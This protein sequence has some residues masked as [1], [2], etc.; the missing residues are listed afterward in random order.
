MMNFL[1]KLP[2]MKLEQS[3]ILTPRI[4]SKV[5]SHIGFA[6]IFKLDT[7]FQELSGSSCSSCS[8]KQ[9]AALKKPGS[10]VDDSSKL[11]SLRKQRLVQTMLIQ[12]AYMP[13]EIRRCF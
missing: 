10:I 7:L 11:S 3:D 2:L 13:T 12:I 4:R 6:T 8:T 9:L 5:K 1:T